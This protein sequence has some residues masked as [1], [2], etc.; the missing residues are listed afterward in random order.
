MSVGQFCNRDTV[1]VRKHDTIVEAAKLMRQH[2]VGCVIVV[3][4]D[5]HGTVTPV[6]IVTD[7]DLVVE[8]LA[9]E[10]DPDVVTLGDIMSFELV[11]AQE[12]DRLWDTLQRMRIKGVRRIPVVDRHGA[13]KGILC[14]DDL[15]EV[16]AGEMGELAKLISREQLRELKTRGM[17]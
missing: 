6:G 9:K 1:I 15:L 8:I 7:R 16:L 4:D 17:E 3:E 13:L 10:V 5:A 12:D 14:S 2:H 11:A